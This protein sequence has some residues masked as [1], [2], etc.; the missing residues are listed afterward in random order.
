MKVGSKNSAHIGQNSDFSKD[1]CPLRANI[2]LPKIAK[3]ELHQTCLRKPPRLNEGVQFVNRFTSLY[4][5][6]RRTMLQ[7]R[8]RAPA[9]AISFVSV[10]ILSL[11]PWSAIALEDFQVVETSNSSLLWG[12]YRPNLYFGV[13][14]RIPQ[15]LL[16]GLMWA[17]VDN[18]ATV[19]N[20]GY[21]STIRL[22]FHLDLTLTMCQCRLQTHLRTT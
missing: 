14:P 11:S 16:T 22:T 15:S 12:P 3:S 2:V 5:L 6:R 13:R 9:L 10:F 4:E 18:F 21:R 20:S 17:K 7:P 1:K 8:L 19:Q